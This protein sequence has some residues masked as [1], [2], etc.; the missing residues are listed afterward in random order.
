MKNITGALLIMALM[1]LLAS[2]A[3]V[4]EKNTESSA[5]QHENEH[6]IGG[7]LYRKGRYIHHHHDEEKEE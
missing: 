1:S 6:H 4:G 2:C 7:H 5:K 3:S